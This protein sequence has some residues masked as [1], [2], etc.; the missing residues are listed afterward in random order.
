MIKNKY[1]F[2]HI[3]P[4]GS[5]IH[6]SWVVK[7]INEQGLSDEHCFIMAKENVYNAN[8]MYKNVFFEQ[9]LNSNLSLLREYMKNADYVIMHGM[10]LS[11]LQLYRLPKLLLKK[12]I[13]VVWGSDIYLVKEKNTT[14]KSFLKNIYRDITFKLKIHRI[15]NIRGIGFG[16]KYDSLIVNRLFGNKVN[17]YNMPYFQQDFNRSEHSDNTA[18]IKIM[19]GHSAFPFLNHIEMLKKL[20]TYRDENIC[21]S[22]VLAYGHAVYKET[23]LKTALE[24]FGSDKV[25]IIDKTLSYDDYVEYIK[26]IDIA[27]LDFTHQSALGNFY[28]LNYFGKKMY[29]NEQG[30]L[31][32]CCTIEGIKTYKTSQIGLISFQ[33]F[34]E[35][36]DELSRRMMREF[37]AYYYDEAVATNNWLLSFGGIKNE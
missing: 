26:T 18:P 1:K 2:V 12:V 6:I 34:V 17:F 5:I 11:V 24:L 7:M 36:V 35:P 10:V 31:Y 33:D 32:K 27:V 15:K 29:L 8:I 13:W 4:S 14:F 20:Q 16:F 9:D 21:V 19:I 25:E 23:V 22:L 28:L 30:I 37:A 3:V